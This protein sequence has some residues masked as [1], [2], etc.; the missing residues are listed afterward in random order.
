MAIRTNWNVSIGPVSGPTSFTNRVTGIDIQQS[1]DV[2][3]MGRGSCTITLLNTDG[4]LT[5]GGGGAYSSY[6]WFA[7]G[8]FVSSAT[9]IGGAPTTVQV[10]HG[11]I[12]DFELNDDG[13][14]S[15]VTITALDGLTIGGRTPNA[16]SDYPASID[17]ATLLTYLTSNIISGVQIAYPRL[18]MSGATAL[19]NELRQS[20]LFNPDQPESCFIPTGLGTFAT[21]ADVWQSAM[22]PTANDVMWATTIDTS[23]S[24]V[25]YNYNTISFS[26]SRAIANRI[27]ILFGNEPLG[28]N[29]LPFRPESF[30][31]AFNN[32]ELVTNCTY[33]ALDVGVTASSA[34][35][36]TVNTYGNRAQS[37]TSTAA[38]SQ[39]M[40]VR[41][42]NL[43]V[44]RYG[45]P[46]FSPVSL[47]VSAK[48][49]QAKCNDAAQARWNILLGISTGL[50]QEASVSWT[51]KGSAAQ[52]A[53]CIIK[54][55][56]IQVTPAD[57]I[58]TIE[59]GNWSDNHSF[60]LDYDFLDQ[61]KV[62]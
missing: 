46:R 51:G 7:Q 48:Q 26:N 42:A 56:R 50:W 31:Q 52:V 25:R 23:G 39:S 44:N 12:V 35:A 28:A 15:T 13:R 40:M 38:I 32:S 8:V 60:V 33:D 43:I 59:L 49:V 61:D 58:I 18:G 20:V 55:R 6:D 37:F 9:D 53:S 47:S 36:S 14:F 11:V 41:N 10:F 21:A 45:T 17:Y 57:A 29:T 34:T 2:N 19:Q 27:Q 62:N 22:I 4:A 3:V 54:G 1:V 24:N 30:T 5:P 16:I